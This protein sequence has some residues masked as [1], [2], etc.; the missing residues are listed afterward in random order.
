MRVLA[1][2]TVGNLAGSA[3]FERV[4]VNSVDRAA[5]VVEIFELDDIVVLFVNFVPEMRNVCFVFFQLLSEMFGLKFQP[6]VFPDE[7]FWALPH[8]LEIPGRLAPRRGPVQGR[9]LSG[10][11]G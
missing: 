6:L 9:P 1:D 4:I 8:T 2:A 3:E 10:R 7:N 5:L 11:R